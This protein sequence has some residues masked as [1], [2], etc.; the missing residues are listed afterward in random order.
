[1]PKTDCKEAYFQQQS[2]LAETLGCNAH[3]NDIDAALGDL[4]RRAAGGDRKRARRR[5]QLK[6]AMIKALRAEGVIAEETKMVAD[7]LDRIAERLVEP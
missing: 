7:D 2:E 4:Q 1:M 3:P 5:V 6:T